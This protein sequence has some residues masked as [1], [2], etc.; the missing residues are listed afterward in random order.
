MP[1]NERQFDDF[2]DITGPAPKLLLETLPM[3]KLFRGGE[4]QYKFLVSHYKR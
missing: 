1:G 4:G 3:R 2:K